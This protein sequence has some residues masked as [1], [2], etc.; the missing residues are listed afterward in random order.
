MKSEQA[1]EGFV[2]PSWDVAAGLFLSHQ[3]LFAQVHPF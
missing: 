2:V 1:L 3:M